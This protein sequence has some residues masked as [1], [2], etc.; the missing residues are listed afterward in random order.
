MG[1]FY[2]AFCKSRNYRVLDLEARAALL[3]ALTQ[4]F[5][6]DNLVSLALFGSVPQGTNGRFSDYDF[7]V[8]LQE[9]SNDPHQRETASPR[10]KRRLVERGLNQLYAFNIYTQAEFDAADNLNSWIIETMKNGNRIIFDSDHYLEDRLEDKKSS[11][12]QVGMFA[13]KGIKT[14]S[15]DRFDNITEKHKQVADLIKNISPQLA[16]FH[17][18]ESKRGEMIAKLFTHGVYMTRGSML[19]L[20]KKLVYDFGEEIDLGIIAIENFQH[21]MQSM[22]AIYSQDQMYA[23]LQVADVLAKNG[24]TQDALLHNYIAL[25]VIYL[26]ILHN[27][28]I[29]AVDGE[30]TQLF[31]R[32]FQDR[33]PEGVLDLIYQNSFKAEQILGRSGYQSFDM[34]EEGK[35]IYEDGGF[36]YEDLMTN[37]REIIIGLSGVEVLSTTKIDSPR[38]S[39]VI[40][41]YNRYEYL[42]KCIQS[43]DKLIIPREA[44]EIIVVDDGSDQEYDIDKL[45]ELT[46][47]NIRYVKKEHS[48]VSAT[49]NQ[50]IKESRGEYLAFLDDDMEVSPLWLV[51]LLSHFGDKR[52]AGVGSTNLTY[53]EANYLNTY[54]DYRQLLRRPF[55]DVTGEVLNVITASACIRKEVLGEVGGFNQRQ[56]KEGVFFGGDDVD[57]TYAIRNLG[58]LFNYAEDAYAFHNH[59]NNLRSFISQ[60]VGYGEGTMFHCLDTQRD[61]S[62]LG[63]SNPT[64]RGVV[65]DLFDYLVFEVPKRAIGVYKDNLGIS[66][67]LTYPLLD[68]ARRFFYDMGILKARRFK[69]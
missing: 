28:D 22:P 40:A 47:F 64:Y 23:N 1:G 35:P 59:R 16:N 60:H 51:R 30:I 17:R 66:K 42:T 11:V 61:P 54:S 27:H 9:A 45:K 57:L 50:A 69:K 24:F 20:A 65:K 13:W 67:S 37:L 7:T 32:E 34:N 52:I 48:G 15:L 46:A 21:E 5:G 62:E 19:D 39:I 58:Y 18:N 6:K 10:L 26:Q 41:T 63:I 53:P 55:R 8:I 4:E 36:D 33:I 38:V 44:V 12:K 29:F 14:E 49:K 3:E 31:I 68:F 43:L 2:V 56:A 25:K